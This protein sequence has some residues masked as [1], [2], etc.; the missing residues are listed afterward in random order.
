MKQSEAYYILNYISEIERIKDCIKDVE[1]EIERLDDI[2]FDMQLPSCPNG[3]TS[4]IIN[5]KRE[6]YIAPGGS[7]DNKREKKILEM[8]SKQQQLEAKKAYYERQKS[9]A[10]AVREYLVEYNYSDY[11]YNNILRDRLILHKSLGYLECEYCLSTPFRT[12]I[13]IIKQAPFPYELML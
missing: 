10:E 8:Y 4:V 1:K 9:T 2:I 7:H 3:G 5:G 13:M 11:V 12:V 6:T